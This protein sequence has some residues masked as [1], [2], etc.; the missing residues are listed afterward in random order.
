MDDFP[1]MLLR[2]GEHLRCMW[3]GGLRHPG[4]PQK[5]AACRQPPGP[6]APWPHGTHGHGPWAH[7]AWAKNKS[8]IPGRPPSA[9]PWPPRNFGFF[10][11]GIQAHGAWDHAHGSHGVHGAMPMG[12]MGRV[13]PCPWVSWVHGACVK[14]TGGAPHSAAAQ[15]T[16]GPWGALGAPG[17]IPKC[18]KRALGGPCGAPGALGP[19]GP[20]TSPTIFLLCCCAVG[21]TSG[22]F[23]TGLVMALNVRSVPKAFQRQCPRRWNIS[24]STAQGVCGE[25]RLADNSNSCCSEPV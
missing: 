20:P 7:G 19:W 12:V 6:R 17:A 24:Q 13:G 18:H 4:P 11:P 14:C 3:P 2:C 21:S 9:R 1:S 23:Y 15:D 10:G 22:A 5:S 16:P 25:G 8:K